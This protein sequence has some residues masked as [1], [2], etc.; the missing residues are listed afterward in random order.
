MSRLTGWLYSLR[1]LARRNAADR[2]MADEIEFHIDRQTRKHE[3]QGLAGDDARRRALLEFG[4]T[5]RW[6]EEARYARGSAVVDAVEQDLRHT[7]RGL[8]RD[9]LFATMA[10]TTLALA[11][12]AN[13]AMFGIL[14]RRP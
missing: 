12:G 10:I 7:L 14:Q 8:R 5:S 4:G 3:A 2:D 11:I 6:R 1:S 13:A 9:P